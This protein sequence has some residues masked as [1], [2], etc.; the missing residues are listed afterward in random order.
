MD[1]NYS[2]MIG[3]SL[4][5]DPPAAAEK[6]ADQTHPDIY[7]LQLQPPPSPPPLRGVY[8]SSFFRGGIRT[9]NRPLLQH[10]QVRIAVNQTQIKREYFNFWGL[11]GHSFQVDR[12]IHN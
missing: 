7:Q 1:I 4:K 12:S 11:G 8:S 10:T 5:S 9:Y 2:S 6:D 3:F